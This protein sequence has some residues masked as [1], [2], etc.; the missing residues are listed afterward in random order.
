ME[1]I[2]PILL[3]E[4][5]AGSSDKKL[6][7][8]ISRLHKKGVIRK[9]AP[10][11]YTPN[12]EETAEE[13][14]RRN[15]FGV[16]GLLYPGAMLSHRS[17]FEF[18]PTSAGH[19]FLTH[20]YTR[21]VSLPG[22]TIRFLEGPGPVGGDRTFLGNLKVSQQARAFLENL[23]GSQRPGPES[24]TLSLPETEEKLEQII[25]LHGEGEINR[26]RDD[27][28][29]LAGIL[30]MEKEFVRLETIIGALLS[31]RDAGVL[32]TSL[33]AARA[34]GSP[35]DPHRVLLFQGLFREL[36]AT[37]YKLREEVNFSSGSFRNFAFFESYFSNYIEG[38]VFGVE[39]ARRIVETDKPLPARSEDSHDILGT[40]RL[41]SDRREMSVIPRTADELIHLLKERHRLLLSARQ[42]K[43]P[44][45]F[46]EQNNKAGNTVFVDKELVSGTLARGFEIYNA[47]NHPFKRA[48]FM[49]FLISEVHPFLDGNGRIARIMMNAELVAA[50]QAKIIVPTV[51]RD[52]YLGALRQLTRR[53]QSGPYLRMLERVYEFSLTIRGEKIDIMQQQLEHSNAFLEPTEGKLDFL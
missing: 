14:I 18:E 4:I 32:T 43:Q 37:Y 27:A 51:F 1:K 12:F 15:L 21:K 5:I 2:P 40:Y 7:R 29:V 8:Q 53:S 46:K 52:D 38:T 50:G 23:Q 16:L 42:H 24:K 35:Y 10:R 25:R 22:I 49:L 41:V 44:G 30:G 39:E 6:N 3:N 47:L 19:I 33:G 26:L 36:E 31:T 45:L 34:I 20:S 48:A 17:A 13:I 11:L 28:R 9:I